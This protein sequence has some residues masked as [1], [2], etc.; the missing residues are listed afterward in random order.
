MAGPIETRD[1]LGRGLEQKRSASPSASQFGPGFRAV[2]YKAWT[3]KT[4]EQP[5]ML[6]AVDRRLVDAGEHHFLRAFH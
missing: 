2:N 5:M 3:A 4:A 6:E 1:G